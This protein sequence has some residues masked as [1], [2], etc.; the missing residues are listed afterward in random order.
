MIP[1]AQKHISDAEALAIRYRVEAARLGE[2]M[3]KIAHVSE[4]KDLR[5]MNTRL[6]SALV[7]ADFYQQTAD[8][9]RGVV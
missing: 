7:R 9:L 2:R 5:E 4:V 6:E 1:N 3:K 8:R